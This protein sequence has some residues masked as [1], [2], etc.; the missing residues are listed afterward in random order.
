MAQMKP[1]RWYK[2]FCGLWYVVLENGTVRPAT[3]EDGGK[4][5]YVGNVYNIGN[6]VCR[7]AYKWE[8]VQTFRVVASCTSFEAMLAA[9]RLLSED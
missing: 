4:H 2:A 7:P 9:K 8:G 3:K 1:I 6:L 5:G